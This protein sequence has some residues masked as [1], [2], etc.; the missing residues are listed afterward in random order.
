MYVFIDLFSRVD[1]CL[2]DRTEE[3]R[4]G[5]MFQFEYFGS[6]KHASS[7]TAYL[8]IL[9]KKETVGLIEAVSKECTNL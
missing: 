9:W 2:E 1:Q 3:G 8:T 4:R 7:D 5:K 6:L